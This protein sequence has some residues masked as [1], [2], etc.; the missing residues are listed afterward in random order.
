[1]GGGELDILDYGTIHDALVENAGDFTIQPNS[2]AQTQRLTLNGTLDNSGTLSVN[3]ALQWYPED[4][5]LAV[6]ADGL[7]LE[8]GGT[9][10]LAANGGVAEIVGSGSPATLE[11]VDNTI[12]GSGQV[13]DSNLTIQNDPSGVIDA[14]A[15]W[16]D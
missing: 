12:E 4:G 8:G 10:S 3:G 7:T 13:G 1:M 15:S 9:V 14:N 16:Q 5:I 2:F 6:G 11:N